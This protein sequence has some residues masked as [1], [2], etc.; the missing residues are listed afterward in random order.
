MNAG[1]QPMS[2]DGQ[3]I[4]GTPEEKQAEAEQGQYEYEYPA[5][6]SE[7]YIPPPYALYNGSFV[8][9]QSEKDQK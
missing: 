1:W 7:E 9:E 5:S 8:N 2:E 3:V 6:N 4:E